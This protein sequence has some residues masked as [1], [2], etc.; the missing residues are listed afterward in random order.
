MPEGVGC[1]PLLLA[2]ASHHLSPYFPHPALP[3][4]STAPS[5]P[6]SIHPCPAFRMPGALMARHKNLL[7]AAAAA[8][9]PA[10]RF[11]GL[12]E[13]RRAEIATKTGTRS[14]RQEGVLSACQRTRE[15]HKAGQTQLVSC[16]S[17]G[18]AHRGM[19]PLLPPPP[20]QTGSQ[21]FNLL[22]VRV[23]KDWLKLCEW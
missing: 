7:Q 19:A 1:T 4:S 18:S 3:P 9:Q 5:T 15:R 2:A 22:H 10:Q 12:I 17:L 14:T 16:R 20:S 8:L 23:E 6:R 21:G 11:A 13:A